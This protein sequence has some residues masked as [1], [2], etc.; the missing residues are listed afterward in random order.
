MPWISCMLLIIEI[1]DTAVFI[2]LET[3][4]GFSFGLENAFFSFFFF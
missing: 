2:F 3:H 4:D 1:Y